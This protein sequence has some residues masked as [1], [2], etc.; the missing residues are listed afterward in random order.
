MRAAGAQKKWLIGLDWIVVGGILVSIRLLTDE[1]LPKHGGRI[2]DKTI[3]TYEVCTTTDRSI[4]ELDESISM[5]QK[6]H[7]VLKLY[8]ESVAGTLSCLCSFYMKNFVCALRLQA[9]FEQTLNG[10]VCL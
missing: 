8:F 1:Q 9:R 2:T 6:R 7:I 3:Y 4:L 10:F 5:R